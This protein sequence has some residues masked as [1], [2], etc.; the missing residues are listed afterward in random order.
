MFTIVYI[1]FGFA[2]FP[3]LEIIKPKII[4]ENTMNAHL[5]EFRLMP[6]SLHFWKHNLWRTPKLLVRLKIGLRMPNIGIVWE[7]GARSQLSALE[8]V[9]GRAEALGLD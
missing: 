2:S 4:F 6:Y 7:L 3:S 1:F 5:S 8:G 9:E